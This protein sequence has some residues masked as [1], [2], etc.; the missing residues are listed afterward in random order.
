MIYR[1]IILPVVLHGYET[2]WLKLRE[3]RRPRVLE[4]RVLRIIFGSTKDNVT[5][6]SKK[7]HN[8]EFT[9]RYFPPN[10]IRVIKSRRMRKAEHVARMV[11]RRSV[12]RVL[13]AKYEAKRT[14][15]RPRRR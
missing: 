9:D 5:G 3:E 8:E 6:E 11:E 4:N 7:P 13:V 15:G 10:I 14:L 1:T 2:W 12:C